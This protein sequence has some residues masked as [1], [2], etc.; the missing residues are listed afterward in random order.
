LGDRFDVTTIDNGGRRIT[1][2]PPRADGRAEY[3]E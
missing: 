3:I 2:P 1:P